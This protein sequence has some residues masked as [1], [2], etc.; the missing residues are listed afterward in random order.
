MWAIHDRK[1]NVL[2]MDSGDLI[3]R[4][5]G[6]VSLHDLALNVAI[7]ECQDV[8]GFAFHRCRSSVFS[9]FSS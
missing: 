7:P 8:V 6:V 4:R 5:A 9:S 3:G 1:A 2:P